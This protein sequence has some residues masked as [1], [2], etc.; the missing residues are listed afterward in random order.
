VVSLEWVS[1]LRSTLIEAKWR[2]HGRIK[3]G[4]FGRVTWK[5]D[6]I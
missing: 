3:W 2:E 4:D 6:I 1:G 5:E